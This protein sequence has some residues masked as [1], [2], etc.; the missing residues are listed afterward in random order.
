MKVH[1]IRVMGSCL[2]REILDLV[3]SQVSC[4][5]TISFVTSF[6]IRQ[7]TLGDCHSEHAHATGG[8][9]FPSGKEPCQSIL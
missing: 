9:N 2:S 6:L 3:L 8:W 1:G 5:V 4:R 7:T